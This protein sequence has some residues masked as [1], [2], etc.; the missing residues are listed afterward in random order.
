LHNTP[1][2]LKRILQKVKK[3]LPKPLE[4]RPKKINA[5]FYDPFMTKPFLFQAVLVGNLDIFKQLFQAGCSLTEMGEECTSS[6]S[7]TPFKSNLV[8]AAAY[9]GRLDILR[10]ILRH[11]DRE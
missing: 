5:S 9:E 6:Q 2:I 10:E 11:V 4:E 3:P 7:L 1:N 8:G